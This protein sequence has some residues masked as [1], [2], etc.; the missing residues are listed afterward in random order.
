MVS[1]QLPSTL[2]CSM[3][4]PRGA[5]KFIAPICHSS[6]PNSSMAPHY[7]KWPGPCPP[8]LLP[9]SPRV[10]PL[11]PHWSPTC[12]PRSYLRAFASAVS[13]PGMAFP[14]SP[15]RLSP[16]LSDFCLVASSNHQAIL[17]AFPRPFLPQHLFIIFTA[18]ANFSNNDCISCFLF[19]G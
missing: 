9:L 18:L 14:Q 7:L 8:P 17:A 19:P 10:S 2:P 3:Q 6:A 4:H 1:P 12:Q 5:F 16:H 13:P 11:Q 15:E